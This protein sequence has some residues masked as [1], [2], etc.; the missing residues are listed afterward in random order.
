LQ[1]YWQTNID[2]LYVNG[3][4]IASTTDSIIDSVTTMILGDNQTVQALYDQIPSSFPM[5]SGFYSSTGNRM[6]LCH[7]KID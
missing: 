2:A 6:A 4:Q 5:K 1:G 7:R 3:Q